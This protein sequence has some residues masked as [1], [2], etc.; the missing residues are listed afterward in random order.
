MSEAHNTDEN[1]EAQPNP[2]DFK[3]HKVQIPVLELGD[4][5][6]CKN[7]KDMGGEIHPE[8]LYKIIKLKENYITLRA[9]SGARAK[10]N[11]REF[12][13]ELFAYLQ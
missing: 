12:E 8:G 3:G 6:Y 4:K 10:T 2:D 5:I 13:S 11:R 1:T 7:V 9:K